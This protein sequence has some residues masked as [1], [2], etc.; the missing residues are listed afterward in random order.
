MR[1]HAM[2]W[3]SVIVLGLAGVQPARAQVRQTSCRGG[4]TYVPSPSPSKQPGDANQLSGLAVLAADDAWVVGWTNSF[5]GGGAYRTLAEHWDGKTW[6]VVPTPNS[7][8]RNNYLNSVTAIASDDVW[9]VG[10]EDDNS[11]DFWT[12][13]MHW[14]GKAWTIDHS[15]RLPGAFGDVLAVSPSNVWAGGFDL[16]NFDGTSWSGRGVGGAANYLGDLS[17]SAK[18]LWAV[19]YRTVQPIGPVLTF[20]AHWDGS[21]WTSFEGVNPLHQ[22]VDDEDTFTGVV[23]PPGES[24]PWAVG[25]FAR[26][27]G[28]P[29]AHTLVEHWNGSKWERVPAPNPGSD[30][31]DNMLWDVAALSSTSL[32]AVGTYGEDG[33]PDNSALIEHWDGA[34]WKVVNSPVPGVLL[35]VAGDPASG[36]VWAAGYTAATDHQAPLILQG[37]D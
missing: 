20:S 18:D 11:G 37:C 25:Y 24:N 22:S 16:A 15:V 5:S 4:W 8:Q 17:G 14:D 29:K 12:L 36:I 21:N 3:G 35:T 7:G 1:F 30:N 19:G 9:A 23:V 13:V 2:V 32:W 27:D 31:K 28:G 33:S 34:S 6:R 10:Q 26:F